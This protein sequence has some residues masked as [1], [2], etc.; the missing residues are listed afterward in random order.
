MTLSIGLNA[1]LSGLSVTAEQTS[2]VSRNVAR[3][4]DP[5]ASRKV[6]NLVTV[7][8]GGVKLASITRAANAALYDKMLGATSDAGTQRAIVE[9]LDHLDQT[10]NDPALEASPAARVAKLANA[11][12]RYAATPQDPTAARSAITAADDLAQ[13]LNGAT[14]TVQQL[15]GQADA[16]IAAAVDHVNTLLAQF[17]SLNSQIV[18]GTRAGTDVTDLLDRRDQV[19]AGIAEEVGVRTVARG[20][21]DTAVYTDSGVTLFDVRARPVGF[22]RTLLFTAT[23]SGNAVYIDGVP[24][25]G[26]GGPMLAGSGRL[27]GL[28]AARD[29]IAVTYQSQLD[30]MARGLIEVF[31]ESDQSAVP[32]LPNAPGLFTYSGAPAMPAGGSLLVGL[33]GSIRVNASVDPAQGGDPSRLRDGAISNPGNPAYDYNASGAAGY[34]Q[35]LEQLLDRLNAQQA[36]DP[37]AQGPASATVAGFAASSVAWLH[38][39]R[40]TAGADSEYKTALLERASD[41]LSKVTGVNLDEEMTLLLELERSYQ[42]STRLITTIDNMLGALLQAAG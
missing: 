30:E 37:T 28:A 4:G 39:A 16:E 41:A 31:A 23:T 14:Q 42:A 38:D 2:V 7:P 33:A 9:A 17:E 1:A 20:D 6:A 34:S 27:T 3:A 40:K 8:G 35:R 29:S 26:S 18:K 5:G 13:A 32:T 12:Q 21:N 11:I 22:D 25:T 15:R 24:I 19:L 36:F 10:V